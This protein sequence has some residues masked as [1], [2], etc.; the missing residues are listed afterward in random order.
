MGVPYSN[1]D[2]DTLSEILVDI[3][4]VIL[5]LLLHYLKKFC[6]YHLRSF[7]PMN[8]SRLAVSLMGLQFL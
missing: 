6:E 4:P 8:F 5:K 1:G 3:V 2:V 7:C